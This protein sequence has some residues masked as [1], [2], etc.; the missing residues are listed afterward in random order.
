MKDELG[1]PLSLFSCATFQQHFRTTYALGDFC[2]DH[3]PTLISEAYRCSKK[4][5]IVFHR[6]KLVLLVMPVLAANLSDK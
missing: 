4:S 5:F 3:S 2:K 6:H 1:T